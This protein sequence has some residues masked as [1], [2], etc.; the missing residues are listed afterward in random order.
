MNPMAKG[1]AMKGCANG[2]SEGVPQ[3][4]ETAMLSR[5]RLP[6]NAGPTEQVDPTRNHLFYDCNS[7]LDY[8]YNRL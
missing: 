8:C 6:G 5:G 4:A 3:I 7:S 2:M 1:P